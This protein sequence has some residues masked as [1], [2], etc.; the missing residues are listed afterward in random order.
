MDIT[1]TDL[2]LARAALLFTVGFVGGL[3]RGFI[4]SGGAFVLTPAM[5]NIGVTPIM[6]VASN[7]CRKFP[8]ALV[9]SMKRAKYGQVDASTSAA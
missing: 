9:G 4:G 7:M 6:A 1:F 5:I 3:V 2:S 8:K